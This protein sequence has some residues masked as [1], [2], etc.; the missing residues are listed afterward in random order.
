MSHR[1]ISSANE[2]PLKIVI[3]CGFSETLFIFEW[4]IQ[5]VNVCILYCMCLQGNFTVINPLE[6]HLYSFEFV[7]HIIRNV[8]WISLPNC[9]KLNEMHIWYFSVQNEQKYS[10]HSVHSN[11]IK[12]SA[13]CIPINPHTVV[14]R[15]L[16]DSKLIHVPK[17]FSTYLEKGSNSLLVCS[18][19]VCKMRPE[20]KWKSAME[21]RCDASGCGDKKQWLDYLDHNGHGWSIIKEL[22]NRKP[23]IRLRI[24]EN[25]R[26]HMFMY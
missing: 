14:T 24:G 2:V 13:M 26:A 23:L 12:W 16:V 25:K 18:C 7:A 10:L 4:N 22:S 21:M 5:M 6:N 11:D 19:I 15:W 8:I 3:V 1:Q 9:W 17:S 20:W